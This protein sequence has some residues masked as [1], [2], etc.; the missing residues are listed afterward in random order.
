MKALDQTI[1]TQT[2]IKLGLHQSPRRHNV[3]TFHIT[4]QTLKLFTKIKVEHSFK[5]KLQK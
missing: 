2:E 5:S 1:K 4:E 3:K